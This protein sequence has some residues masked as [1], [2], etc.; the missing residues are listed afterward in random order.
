ML[1]MRRRQGETI[2]IGDEIEIHIAHIGRSRV[3]IGIH[4]PRDLRVVAKEIKLVGEE[5]RAAAE[6]D[7]DAGAAARI[8]RA[9]A[10]TSQIP[11]LRPIRLGENGEAEC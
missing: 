8:A 7:V 6:A 9:L 5:N 4:A 3:K 10:S 2:L 11:E 1:V